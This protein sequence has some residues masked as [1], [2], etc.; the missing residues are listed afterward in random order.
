MFES[1]PVTLLGRCATEEEAPALWSFVRMVANKAKAT[2]P[3]NIII[4]LDQC[5][6]VTESPVTLNSGTPAPLGRTL[7]LPLPYLAFMGRDEAAAVIGHELA[8][9]QGADTEYSLKFSPIYATAVRN[10][11]AIHDVDISGEGY[12]RWLM[13]PAIMLGEFFLRAFDG[14]VQ[15]W[16]RQRE[17]AA[18]AVGAAVSDKRSIALSLLRISVL[19]PRIESALVECW[20]KAG[21]VQGGILGKII[22]DV[23]SQGV[24][25]PRAHLE[26]E[27]PHPTDSHPTTSQRLAALGVEVDAAL[28]AAA[29]DLTGSALLQELDLY[30]TTDPGSSQDTTAATK[31]ARSALGLEAE[32]ILAA[33]ESMVKEIAALRRPAGEGLETLFL[34][35]G[36]PLFVVAAF[37]IGIIAS[38][39]AVGLAGIDG[40]G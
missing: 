10:L 38:L 3:T 36:S 2:L 35:E 21:K 5:F 27:Q 24:G 32:F 18:D 31:E 17:L 34:Y 7:Y 13:K 6:F 19:S 15:H 29:G 37:V 22:R 16:S 11:H 25:D 39:S 40:A 9:F 33:D 30:E 28:L 8:H 12:L 23:K 4:G 26:D 14:A 1:W 20:N